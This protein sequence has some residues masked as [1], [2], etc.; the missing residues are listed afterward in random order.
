MT[1]QVRIFYAEGI[2]RVKLECRA[3][4][5][6]AGR[7]HKVSNEGYMKFQELMKGY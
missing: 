1:V 2:W 7:V 3:S 4:Q 5:S 6:E